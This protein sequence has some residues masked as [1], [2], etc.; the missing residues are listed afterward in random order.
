MGKFQF[1]AVAGPDAAGDR[2]G[3][4]R[5]AGRFEADAVH[6]LLVV[7]IA[8]QQQFGEVEG[9]LVFHRIVG[10]LM[11]NHFDGGHGA[12]RCRAEIEVELLLLAVVTDARL[13]DYLLRRFAVL[14]QQGFGIQ[15]DG[16]SLAAGK[17]AG[18]VAGQGCLQRQG[19]KPPPILRLIEIQAHQRKTLVA[20]VGLRGD[21]QRF[22]A[23][24]SHRQLV[25]RHRL[26]LTGGCQQ[27]DGWRRP[28]GIGGLG[29]GG[30]QQ[31][32]GE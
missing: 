16:D 22:A 8:G 6:H 3:F 11:E 26:P 21:F 7:R 29:R 20:A 30:R 31:G 17:H 14:V 5:S 15:A 9:E 32:Q 19:V 13:G 25:V 28:A 24:G 12:A 27:I 2:S 18:P 1:Q 23:F 4:R 10:L